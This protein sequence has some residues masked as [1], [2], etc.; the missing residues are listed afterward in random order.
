MYQFCTVQVDTIPV[1]KLWVWWYIYISIAVPLVLQLGAVLTLV[2]VLLVHYGYRYGSQGLILEISQVL[3][4]DMQISHFVSSNKLFF[5]LL[6]NLKEF[7]FFQQTDK[8]EVAP[9]VY[10]LITGLN[11]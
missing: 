11:M 5:F 7:F 8:M 10:M 4:A 2:P 1:L 6:L 9:G 3:R